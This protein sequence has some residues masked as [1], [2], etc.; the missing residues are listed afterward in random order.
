MIPNNSTAVGAT[1][2]DQFRPRGNNPAAQPLNDPFA[3]GILQP[4]GNSLGLATFEGQSIIFNNVNRKIPHAHQFSFG[5]EQQLPYDVKVDASYVGS[6]TLDIN[7]NDNQ[8]GGARN[9]NVLSTHRLRNAAAAA[10]C[11]W[12][13]AAD[14]LY[15]GTAN[16]NGYLSQTVPNPFRRSVAGQQ[17]ER[18]HHQPPAAAAS[19]PA[20]PDRQLTAR[21]RSARSGMTRSS[22]RSRS[23]TRTGSP[24]S[25]AYT[26][27]KTQEALAF[28]N[29][30]DAAPFKNIG[31]QDR[32]QRL[33]D[34]RAC[35]SFLSAAAMPFLAMRTVSQNWR[36]AVGSSTSLRRSSPAFP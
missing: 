13:H 17:P 11:R 18:D 14:G 34:L 21:S 33:V 28:L 2:A 29:N 27:S 5:M 35:T 16:L 9:L 3:T 15:A 24:S 19:L 20:V 12:I 6:R 22:S 25:G 23:V 30:Q 8:A 1:A 32:P 4:T 36:S 10:D 26:W 7:T 31:A